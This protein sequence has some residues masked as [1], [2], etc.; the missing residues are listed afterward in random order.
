MLL[1]DE[2]SM[3]IDGEIDE[4]ALLEK[5]SLFENQ[6]HANNLKRLTS[7]A[8]ASFAGTVAE[9]VHCLWHEVTVR[10]RAGSSTGRAVAPAPGANGAV[11]SAEPGLSPVPGGL[12]KPRDVA[13][14]SS[15][16]DFSSGVSL[17]QI[18]NGL[19]DFTQAVA[20]VNHRLYLTGF[21]EFAQDV[22][23]LFARLSQHH[24]EALAY[25]WRQKKRLDHTN[26]RTE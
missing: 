5:R 26:Q 8:R 25:E 6:S 10:N 23:V 18:P 14:R 17:F 15:Y 20:P 4:Q 1:C 12:R 2:I 11:V 21:H 3:G 24:Y 16:Y 19:R 22:Q 9:Y 13:S 7:Y